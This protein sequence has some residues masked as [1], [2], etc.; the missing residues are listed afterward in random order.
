MDF[1]DFWRKYSWHNWPSN[2]YSGF[3]TQCNHASTQL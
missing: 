3:E 1:N 2:G